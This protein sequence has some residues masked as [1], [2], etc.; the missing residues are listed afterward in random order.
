MRSQI[1]YARSNQLEGVV[2]HANLLMAGEGFHEV[3]NVAA[4]RTGFLCVDGE[5][6][7][8]KRFR[9]RSW[10]EGVLEKFRGSRASR[11][12]RGAEILKRHGFLSPAPLAA[13]EQ[14]WAGLVTDSWLVSEALEQ[15]R[16]VSAFLDRQ[17][18]EPRNNR[19]WRRQVLGQLAACIRRMHEAGL[20]ISDLQ[21][22]NVMLEEREGELRI[23]FVDLDEFREFAQV[24][25]KQRKCNLLQLDCSLECFLTRPER[26]HFLYEY[27]GEGWS[28]DQ[29]RALLEEL[30]DERARKDRNC[31][32]R[33]RDRRAQRLPLEDSSGRGTA[34]ASHRA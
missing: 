7:F 22:T 4:N 3:K 8:I 11:S 21:E 5:T 26:L 32:P 13:A 17:L 6:V 31:R 24:S 9:V 28:P 25:W 2:E 16:S 1:L 30:A 20:F 33:I 34:Q 19:R 12:L 23:Y 18:G 29:V 14:V 27:L 15:A 10:I